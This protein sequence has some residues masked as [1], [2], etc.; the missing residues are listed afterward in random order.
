MMQDVDGG[1]RGPGVSGPQE[2]DLRVACSL[3]GVEGLSIFVDVFCVEL[4]VD[5]ETSFLVI[6]GIPVAVSVLSYGEIQ[7]CTKWLSA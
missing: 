5:C 2:D 3:V 6:P 7:G 1:E 4:E